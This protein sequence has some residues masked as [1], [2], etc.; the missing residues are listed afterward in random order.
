MEKETTQKQTTKRKLEG[1][2]VSDAMN[3][4][5]VVKVNQYLKHPK[6]GKFMKR[7][8]KYKAHDENNDYKVGDKVTIIECR[9]LSREKRFKVL[10]K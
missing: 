6:Y 3:K 2:V 1:V 8:K 9:P 7:T 4:T 5:I 10:A